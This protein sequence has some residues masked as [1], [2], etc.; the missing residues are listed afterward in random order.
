LLCGLLLRVPVPMPELTEEGLG[1]L[2]VHFSAEADRLTKS[3][4]EQF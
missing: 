1:V 2:L 3:L 4:P